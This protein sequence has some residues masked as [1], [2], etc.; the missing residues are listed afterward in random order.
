[1]G[2]LTLIALG[3]T[4]VAVF[5]TVETS[6]LGYDHLA[7]ILGLLISYSLQWIYFD[8]DADRNYLHALRRNIFTGIFYSGCHLPLHAS[9]IAGDIFPPSFFL[10]SC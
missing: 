1:M 7:A 4:I 2:L 10:I 8:V 9:I 6:R 5:F 3:E